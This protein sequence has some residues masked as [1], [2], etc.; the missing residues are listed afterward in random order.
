MNENRKSSLANRIALG[1]GGVSFIM[2]IWTIV[3]MITN[4]Y[5]IAGFIKSEFGYVLIL[6]MINA[7]ISVL[8]GLLIISRDPENRLGW[9]FLAIGFLFSWWQLSNALLETTG[10][11]GI[12]ALLRPIIIAG[13]L[14][15]LLPLMMTMAFVPLFFPTGR[16]LS[17]RWCPVLFIALVGVVGQTLAQGLLDAFIELPELKQTGLEPILMRVFDFTSFILVAGILGSILS[18]IIRFLRSR[19]DER[20]QMKW[21]VYTAVMSISFMLL[22]SLVLGEDSLFL[23]IFSSAIPIYLTIAIGIAILRHRLF[24]IDIIIRRTLQYALLTGLLILVYFGLVITLQNIYA[25]FSN[26][27][28]PI[29]IVIST[30]VIAALF[31]PLR[32][33]VQ[34][35][36]DRR[37][38]RR[39]Y[40]AQR[41]L[42]TFA[43]TARDEVDMENLTTETLRV[44]EESLQ[45]ESIS[46]WLNPVEE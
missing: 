20:T 31:N 12:P 1:I 34:D 40:D 8:L 18:L 44:V 19:G 46:I 24:D 17:R 32:S 37:F 23:G 29:I 2:L 35:F 30:L 7:V 10:L 13:G 27:Q 33:R 15:Y 42:E 16:L 9:L 36:I 14:A 26:Q 21:L 28:S 41:A 22:L 4:W 38:Y 45:P 11:E 3:L 43:A 5:M 39:K 25:S 6:F